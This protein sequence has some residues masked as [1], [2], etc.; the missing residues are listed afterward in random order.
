MFDAG[1]STIDYPLEILN[2]HEAVLMGYGR[3]LGETI[4]LENSVSNDI[5]YYSGIIMKKLN[6]SH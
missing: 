3:H 5:L 1:I 4:R 2:D 6:N